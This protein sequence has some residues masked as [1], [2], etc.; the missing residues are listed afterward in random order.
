M[1]DRFAPIS[2]SRLTRWIFGELESHQATFGVPAS[3]FFRPEAKDPFTLEHQGEALQT[4]IGVAAGPHTQLAQNIIVSYLLGA[5]FIE[6]KTVQTLDELKVTKPCIDAH[7]E[8]Y[9][10]EW[11][12]ELRLE[13]SFDEYLHAYVL[14]HALGHKLDVLGPAAAS[15]APGFAFNLSVGYDLAGIKKDNVQSFLAKMDN[16][17]DALERA[18][19]EVASVYPPVR[20]LTLAP[21]LAQSVT[22]STMHGCPPQEIEEIGRYLLV[23][24]GL[25]TTIKLNPTLLGP[26]LLR[27][28][29]R[30]ELGFSE[31]VVPDEAFAH[32]VRFEDAIAMLERLRA[33]ADERGLSFGVKLTNTLEVQNH[34][35][36]FPAGET[37][38]YMSGRP[39]H[40]LT[41]NVAAKVR[42]AV[43]PMPMSFSGGADAENLGELLAAGLKPVTVCTDLLKPGGYTRLPQYLHQLRE[44]MEAAGAE[45]LESWAHIKAGAESTTPL[46]AVHAHNLKR[47]AAQARDDARYSGARRPRSL[48]G[49]QTLGFFDCIEAPCRGK[50]PANQDI[51]EYL[52][53]VAQGRYDEALSVIRETNPMPSV[54][55]A[56]CD[57]ACEARCVR[58]HY[59]GPLAIRA[60]KR[61]VAGHA[62]A[63]ETH[64]TPG[65]GAPRVGIIGAGPA[66]ISAAYYLARAG[67][68][69][70]VYDAGKN[71]GGTVAATIPSFRLELDHTLRDAE[72]LQELGV[73]LQFNTRIGE[74]LSFSDLLEDFGAVIITS[75]ATVGRKLGVEGES[76]TSAVLDGY[77][78]LTKVKANAPLELGSE[79]A[80]IGGGNAAMDAART[81]WRLVGAEGTVRL[82]YRR[83][84]AEMPADPD[85]IIALDAEGVEIHELAAPLRLVH[86]HGSLSAIECQKMQLGAVDKSGRR[87]PVPVEGETFELPCSAVIA[88]VSQEPA[89]DYLDQEPVARHRW[90]TIKVDE[91][92]MASSMQGVYAAGDAVRGPSTII[93][94][95]ADGRRAASAILEAA[96][97]PTPTIFEPVEAG[98]DEADARKEA[99]RCL[100]CDEMC[101]LCVTVC[102]NMANLSYSVSLRR[103]E[104]VDVE[105]GSEHFEV[106][107]ARQIINIADACNECGNCTTFCPTAGEPYRDKP[108]LCLDE[109]LYAEESDGALFIE[110]EDDGSFVMRAKLG[111]KEHRLVR[112]ES[113]GVLYEVEAERVH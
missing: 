56:V 2:L 86:K 24:R 38:M 100:L 78:F 34:R 94:A 49:K 23:E 32:D 15:G 64:A 65:M 74:A 93:Q 109:A 3:L 33:L 19:E 63:E 61:F 113:G 89:L 22:L 46:P 72:L 54:T 35:E 105:G 77:G 41:V 90:G 28:V 62:S 37:M 76:A 58:S 88:C 13:Q 14:L 95:I 40:P 1:P 87:R 85:E 82:I 108:R 112:D 107:Q 29:L 26:E 73:T 4:P 69:V 18:V 102:P 70:V 67:C 20:D 30:D 92:T 47:H 31:I 75:G 80:I 57:H 10:C 68:S 98:L 97:L 81:A 99:A 11:S 71:P 39:L 55:G 7:D 6:L 84:R 91:A 79:V 52:S 106:T 101:D 42:D 45:D 17:G 104:L 53:L 5:R 83:T 50:C 12:Q 8:T 43:G 44:R 16:A 48:K 111:G 66:G 27:K 96:G 9:N 51:P 21:R 60:I 110:R 36:V 103:V 59:D 25:H